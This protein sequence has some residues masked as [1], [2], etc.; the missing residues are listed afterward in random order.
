M[1]E[2]GLSVNSEIALTQESKRLAEQLRCELHQHRISGHV[3]GQFF[4]AAVEEALGL[5][6]EDL[7]SHVGPYPLFKPGKDN[8]T[9]IHQRFY[10]QHARQK[11]LYQALCRRVISAIGESC[12]FQQIPTYRFGLPANRWVGNF[13]RDSDFGHSHYEIN[14]ICALTPMMGS[15]ALHVEKMDGSHDFE[16]LELQTGEV[17]LFDHIDRLHGCPINREGVSVASIDFRFV[18]A[19][20]AQYAFCSEAISVNTGMPFRPGHY[21]SI[22]PLMLAAL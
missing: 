13:H 8:N 14:A 18:P 19:R 5:P 15:A 1:N 11:I 3:E 2:L 22:E 21:F 20:F 10:S 12:Y 4:A 7:H 17:I 9:D 16:P 6:L